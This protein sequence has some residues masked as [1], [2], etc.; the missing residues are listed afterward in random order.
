MKIERAPLPRNVPLPEDAYSGRWWLI[1]SRYAACPFC[2]LRIDRIGRRVSEL[3]AAGV[4]LL[5]VFPSPPERVEKYYPPASTPFDVVSDTSE[6][7]YDLLGSKTSVLGTLRTAVDIPVVLRAELS[8]LRNPL[9]IDGPFTR[10]PADY[11]VRDGTIE[12]SR[13]GRRLDDGL[14]MEDVLRWAKA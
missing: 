6:T 1:L 8:Y 5:V 10:L 11:L 13:V 12:R 4:K 7:L 9:A 2:S 3:T 14:E